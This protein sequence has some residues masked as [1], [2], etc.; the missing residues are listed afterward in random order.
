M[1][2]FYLDE[3]GDSGANL[4]DEQQPLFV[5]G[6]LNVADKKWNNTKAAMPFLK[7]APNLRQDNI[8]PDP[9]HYFS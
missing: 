6:G 3:S 9:Q 2:F 7:T 8:A 4:N 5:L 1:H